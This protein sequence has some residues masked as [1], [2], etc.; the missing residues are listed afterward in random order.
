MGEDAIDR[1]DHQEGNNGRDDAHI[2]ID[3][4]VTGRRT[5]S[6]NDNQL[7]YG[8]LLYA[9]FAQYLQT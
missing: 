3:H 7:K 2:F 5:E 9:P 8:E 6:Y 4:R 1:N